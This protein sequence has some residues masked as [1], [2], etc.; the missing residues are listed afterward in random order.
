MS[1]AI[2]FYVNF[3]GRR[4]YLDGTLQKLMGEPYKRIMVMHVTI[5]FGGFLAMALGSPLPALMLLI[6]LK[7]GADARA[8]VR[9]RSEKSGL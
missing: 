1:H 8:H 7:I 2:S 9:E 4:E 5:I 6:V 3:I